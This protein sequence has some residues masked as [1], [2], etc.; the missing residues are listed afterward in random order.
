LSYLPQSARDRAALL[1]ALG[2]GSEEELF[3]QIP[4]ALRATATPQLP[5][6]LTEP[7]L[8][9]HASRLADSNRSL[10]DLVC[11]AGGGIYDHFIPSI[12]PAVVVRPEFMTSYTPYQAEASQGMLQAM[13]E[14]QT[15]VCELTAMEVANASLYDGATALGE[16][17]FM[18]ASLTGRSRAVVSR[19]LGPAARQVA[20]TY[21]SGAGIEI[22]E[23]PFDPISGETNHQALGKLLGPEVCCVALQQPNQFGVIE[24]MAAAA[25]LAHGAGALFVA[26]VEPI[27]LA[28]LQPPGEYDA[29]IAVGEGQPLGLA[30]SY[31]GPLLGLFACKGSLMRHMPGRVIGE[32]VDHDG[33][34]AYCLT[35]QAREQHIRREKAT[36][37]ICTSQQLCALAA[38]VYL[39]ALGPDGLREV[40]ELGVQ[41]AHYLRDRLIEAGVGAPRFRGAFGSEFAVRLTGPGDR[42]V[43][44]LAGQGYLVGP[45]LGQAY[46]ELGDCLLL[47]ATEQRTQEE[48]EGLVAALHSWGSVSV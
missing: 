22:I 15:M 20:Q 46:P 12:V 34:L 23:A 10:H 19:A 8:V 4:D 3:H 7:E 13:F 30:P 28:I 33:R 11:F 26:S 25:A 43:A 6:P 21:T 38:A 35:M 41:K 37:N 45:G 31:G 42:A 24:N 27:S 16:A 5:D 9:R 44:D 40:A 1:A 17:I 47:A 39:A 36:S 48:I 14:Y 18:A 29:D 32:T 2:I